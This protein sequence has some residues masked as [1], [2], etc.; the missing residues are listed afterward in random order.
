MPEGWSC[1]NCHKA[2]APWVATC[3]ELLV[4]TSVSVPTVW[5][6]DCSCPPGHMCASTACPRAVR[7]EPVVTV[8]S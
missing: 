3:P 4:S 1:P 5:I 8:T 2:H 7:A 6:K